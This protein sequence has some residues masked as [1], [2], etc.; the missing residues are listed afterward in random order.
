[1][2]FTVS[3]DSLSDA[4][5]IVSKGTSGTSTLPILSCVLIKAE[6]GLIE[7]Q[8]SNYTTSVRHRIAAHVEEAGQLVVPCKLLSNIAKALP[9]APVHIE[10]VDRQALISCEKSNFTLSALDP[11]DFPEFPVYAIEAGVELPVGVLSEMVARVWRVTSKDTVRPILGGV[12]TTVGNNTLTLAATDS[13][14]L[15]M[16]DTNVETS[17]LEGNFELNIPAPA[18]NDALSIMA[19]A[20]SIFIGVSGKQI[21]FEAGN[22]CYVASR[23]EG[24][25]PNVRQLIPADCVV[26]AKIDVEAFSAAFKRVA[27]I[28]KPDIPVR[29]TIDA[30]AGTLTLTVISADQGR[31][32]ETI[33]I[34]V[35]GEGGTIAFKN[36]FIHDCLSALGHQ[37]K[38]ITLEL[39]SYSKM[40]VFKSYDKVN[41]LYLIMPMRV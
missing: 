2:K 28:A 26:R 21:V 16:C 34:E 36:S 11:R 13:M 25:Y 41:Y 40:G 24:E 19:S 17:S 15:A 39:Q 8:T 35:E 3:Q 7:L 27:V 10:S 30:D 20:P 29:F 33:D 14:R 38:E 18:L 23:L 9:D 32:S 6:D 22:T 5:S 12:H 1:M 31:A 4:L 37:E